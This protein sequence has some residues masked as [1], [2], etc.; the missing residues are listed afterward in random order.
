MPTINSA[1]PACHNLSAKLERIR[2]RLAHSR[3]SHFGLAMQSSHLLQKVSLRITYLRQESHS[4]TMSSWITMRENQRL[5]LAK[6]RRKGSW[7]DKL[8]LRRGTACFVVLGPENAGLYLPRS[9]VKCRQ[10]TQSGEIFENQ[11]ARQEVLH[12]VSVDS[13]TFHW[14]WMIMCKI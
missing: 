6:Q 9:C 4:P 7:S 10:S 2:R 14:S 13:G 5:E 1:S 12:Q 11:Q 3:A 8:P